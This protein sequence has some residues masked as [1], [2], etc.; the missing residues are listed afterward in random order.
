MR[1]P[2]AVALGACARA[3]IAPRKA[4]VRHRHHRRSHGGQAHARADSVLPSA[5]ARQLQHRDRAPVR[6][7][8]VI[9]CRVAVQHT[10]GVE[11]EAL[12]GAAR[13][14][15]DGLRHVQG[16]VARHR[17]RRACGCCEN[18]R[19][20]RFRAIARGPMSV[21]RPLYGLVLAGGRSTRMQRDKATLELPRPRAAR[22]RDGA[23]RAARGARLCVR[24]RRSDATTRCAPRFAQ[25]VDRRADARADRR[26][27][28]RAGRAPDAAWLVLA[29]DLPFLDATTLKHL[30]A[31]ARPARASRPP[32]ASSHDGLPEPLCAIYEP[33][34]R[35]ALGPTST[36][37]RHC[38]RKFLIESDAHL[39]RRSPTRARST[40]STRPRSTRGHAPRCNAAPP[41]RQADQSAVL[42]PAA[43][44]GRPQ[45][46][47]AR[48]HGGATPRDSVRG[49]A[50]RGI[51]SRWRRRCCASPS[52]PS[53]ATGRSR[54]RMA[55]PWCSFRRWPA[56]ELDADAL[57][58]RAQ[59]IATR[60]AG[61]R[62][63]ADPACGGYASFEG[64]VRD[65]NEGASVTAS[66]TR[67]SSR[68]RSR[69]A[70]ASSPRPSSASASSTPPACTASAACD[71]RAGRVGGRE[72]RA[73]R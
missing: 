3:G 10:T 69:K 68:W 41:V 46:R 16:P 26:H 5:R 48:D 35:A 29:C 11:M 70:S 23:G 73:S 66:S 55:M 33:A 52:M 51:R 39:H 37:G 53:S 25:I 57:I 72:R 38:P 34:S 58:S 13:R 9:G 22:P 42:R 2:R 19:Q 63:L 40:T 7:G 49:A 62:V 32:I 60:S 8:I 4:G 56:A 14:R 65:H 71:R 67:P 47:D 50:R 20:E 44:A 17:D 21:A 64:W 45:R 61:V 1:L 43:R 27:L 30:I 24:A 12:T 28:A 6:G 36:R 54:W 15:A 31:C 59:P 18:R